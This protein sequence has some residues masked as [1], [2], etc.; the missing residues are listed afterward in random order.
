MSNVEP[1]RPAPASSKKPRAEF[2]W[3]PTEDEL[4]QYGNSVVQDEAW[5]DEMG[6]STADLPVAPAIAELSL[7]SV[8]L[9]E[10]PADVLSREYMPTPVEAEP[11]DGI[12]AS[13]WTAEI[14][15]LQALIDGLTRTV[16]R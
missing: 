10:D 7:P 13:K 8:A 6:L 5:L 1:K 16:E 3:P 9:I 4:E 11:T 2:N 14:A 12:D 15:R